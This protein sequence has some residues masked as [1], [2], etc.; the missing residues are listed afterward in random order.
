VPGGAHKLTTGALRLEGPVGGHAWRLW[1]GETLLGDWFPLMHQETGQSLWVASDTARII[2]MRQ[3]A[4]VT[5]VDMELSRSEPGKAITRIEEKSG[6]ADAQTDAPRRF[7]SGWRFRVPRDAGAWFAAQCLWV[8]NTD[9][10]PWK[11]AE[12]FQY[13]VPALGGDPAGDEPLVGKAPNYYRRGAAWV[14]AGAGVGVGCWYIDEDAFQCSYW[15]DPGGGFHAD[16]HETV[17]AELKPR[18]QVRLKGHLAFVFPLEDISTAGF[19][20]AIARLEE[21]VTDPR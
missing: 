11:L 2:G 3:D 12:V 14:D 8:E 7:S 18:Q 13:L 17:D 1:R 6:R 19:G 9:T 10:E 5:V 16:L 4:R 21:I 15:K 20:K